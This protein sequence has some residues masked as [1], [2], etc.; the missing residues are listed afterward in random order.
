MES[1]GI[2]IVF[3]ITS[4]RIRFSTRQVTI[5]TSIFASSS[6]VYGAN[7]NYPFSETS[8]CSHPIQ[9]YA[10][11][12]LSNEVMAHSYS[13]L[14]NLPTSGI[15]FFTVYGPWGRPDQ[16]LFIFTKNIIENKTINLFD[17]SKIYNQELKTLTILHFLK[18]LDH[19]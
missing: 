18:L 17:W 6:S 15:R 14:Y 19:N 9:L 7:K 8:N 4:P 5:S 12:K 16:A 3:S 1:F 11:T 2:A 10:A 13:S